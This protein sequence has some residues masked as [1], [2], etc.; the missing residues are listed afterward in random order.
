MKNLIR[1][2]NY[3][4]DDI[5]EIFKLADAV[6]KGEY[7]DFLKGKS[8]AMFLPYTSVRT[9]MTFEKGVNA[10]GGMVHL[11]PPETLDKREDTRDLISYL[12]SW[13]DVIIVRHK[14]LRL[15]DLIAQ[16][17]KAPVIN[18]MTEFNHPCEVIAD[19]YAISKLRD[20]YDKCSYLYCGTADHIGNTWNEL[21][22]VLDLDFSQ[23]CPR[24]YEINN[25]TVYHDIDDAIKG[26]DIVLTSSLPRE[27]TDDFKDFQITEDIMSD[28]NEGALLNPGTPFFRGEEVSHDVIESQYF[29]GYEF[30]SHLLEVQQAIIIYNMLS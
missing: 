28:A 14:N 21:A 25:V 9:R 11:F 24:G 20:D 13:A 10:M 27:A 15:L 22:G 26:K 5:S 1:V 7:K 8:V 18:G 2:N 4:K 17:S 16:Y 6:K 19:Y 30:K 29:V 3:T 12:N 23:C